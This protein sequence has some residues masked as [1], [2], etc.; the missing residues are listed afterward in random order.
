MIIRDTRESVVKIDGGVQNNIGAGDMGAVIQCGQE[1]RK[2]YVVNDGQVQRVF[3]NVRDENDQNAL[4][5]FDILAA[6]KVLQKPEKLF[7]IEKF[8]NKLTEYLENAQSLFPDLCKEH[9]K[10]N[11]PGWAPYFYCDIRQRDGR[12]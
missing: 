4:S 6:A 7:K 1:L 8:N 2:R 5:Q 3:Y 10:E 9:V 11:G 12:L